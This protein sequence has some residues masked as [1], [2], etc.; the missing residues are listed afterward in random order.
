[1]IKVKIRDKYR[2]FSH[3]ELLDKAYAL[4]SNFEKYSIGCSQCTVAAIHELLDIEGVVVRVASSLAGGT[5]MQF[6][7]TCGALSGGVMIL[8]YCFGRQP[9]KMSYEEEIKDNLDAYFA[10]T[11]SPMLLADK[12]WKEYGTINCINIQ[13]QLFG[14]FYYAVDPDEYEKQ[15]KAGAHESTKCPHIVGNSARWVMEILLDKNAI[16]L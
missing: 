4:G 11:E 14:R 8:D 12:F 7:G 13:R 15:I 9:N 5:A 16:D 6:V 10:A 2:G 1:M 3:Q